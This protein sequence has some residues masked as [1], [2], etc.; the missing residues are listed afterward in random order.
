MS[1]C[2]DPRALKEPHACPGRC[3]CYV[4]HLCSPGCACNHCNHAGLMKDWKARMLLG[5][6]EGY[7]GGDAGRAVA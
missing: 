1:T 2:F 3:A 6:P 5:V 4:N 7:G